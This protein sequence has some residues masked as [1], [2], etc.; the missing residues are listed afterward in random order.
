MAF[1]DVQPFQ[2]Q[3]GDDF[4]GVHIHRRARAALIHI[5]RK[6]VEAAALVQHLVAGAD[7]GFGNVRRN[8]AQLAV[9]QR[10][11]FFYHHHAAHQFGNIADFLIGNIEIFHRTQSVDAPI[12]ISGNRA[13]A[14][15]VGLNTGIHAKAPEIGWKGQCAQL[16]RI[17]GRRLLLGNS[18]EVA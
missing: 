10:R 15:Q 11:R 16:R 4:I 1:F 5:G 18:P 9:G 6:L 17:I 12:N 8:H 2:R 14:E 3:I 7:N 13:F